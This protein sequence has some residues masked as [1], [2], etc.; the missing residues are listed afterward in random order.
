VDVRCRPQLFPE[1]LAEPVWI[2]SKPYRA[3]PYWCAMNATDANPIIRQASAADGAAYI[4]LVR[5]LA[6]FEKLDPPDDAAAARLLEH[7][8]GTRPRYELRVV[9][10]RRELVAYAAFFETYST[11]RALPSLFLED[12]FVREDARGQGIGESLLRHLARL[13]VERGCGRLEWSVLDWNQP[14]RRFYRSRGATLLEQWQL[15]RVDGDA[16]LSLAG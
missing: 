5:G 9:E 1:P 15:C 14:A 3:E 11:F 16:L 6:A 4:G 10:R 8:F 7:A 13:A 12:L 2:L